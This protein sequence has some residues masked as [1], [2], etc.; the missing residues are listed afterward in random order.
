MTKSSAIVQYIKALC[1]KYVAIITFE[2]VAKHK[3]FQ[4]LYKMPIEVIF[5]RGRFLQHYIHLTSVFLCICEVSCVLHRVCMHMHLIQYAHI[6]WQGS[7]ADWKTWKNIWN[8]WKY[9]ICKPGLSQDW[10]HY[11]WHS[12]VYTTTE[13][14]LKQ[15][16]RFIYIHA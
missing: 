9:L 15:T 8:I 10:M 3:L 1:L 6:T 14:G 7:I 11:L 2:C 13:Q 16:A 12:Q 4:R 5:A